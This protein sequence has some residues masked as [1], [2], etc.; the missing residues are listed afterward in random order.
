[1]AV[2][3][4]GRDCYEGFVSN[5]M[6]D[7]PG[8]VLS[9]LDI[10]QMNQ[11]AYDPNGQISSVL[12][13]ASPHRYA[14]RL[15]PGCQNWDTSVALYKLAGKTLPSGS[16]YSVGLGGHICGGG[17]G[18][19]SRKYGLVCDWLDGVDLLVA[20]ASGSVLKRSCVP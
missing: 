14:F 12:V 8:E 6:P 13:P 20:N 11:L 2:S 1:M 7:A 17:Y 5:K 9:I 10:G 15:E 4:Y 18:L 16:C 19:L 3:R